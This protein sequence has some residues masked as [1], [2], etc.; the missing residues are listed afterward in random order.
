MDMEAQ[1]GKFSYRR[2]DLKELRW[3]ELDGLLMALHGEWT[4]R[5]DMG[6][7]DNRWIEQKIRDVERE[8]RQREER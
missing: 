8:L 7:N 5:M 4:R 3:V 6:Q 1:Q 2:Q